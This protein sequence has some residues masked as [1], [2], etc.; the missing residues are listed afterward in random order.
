VVRRGRSVRVDPVRKQMKVSS[1]GGNNSA[2]RLFTVVRG[3]SGSP[4]TLFVAGCAADTRVYGCEP[5]IR[6]LRSDALQIHT[7]RADSISRGQR[8]SPAA[9][10][11]GTLV[12]PSRRGAAWDSRSRISVASARSMTG[13]S[14]ACSVR[15]C[16][17]MVRRLKRASRRCACSGQ[18]DQGVETWS[19]LRGP[20]RGERR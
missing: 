1:T 3:M 2:M 8:T 12:S 17:N 10:D 7:I 19:T 14:V 20:E 4:A 6:E 9:V 13:T 16:E 18:Q 5:S 11:R 15:N